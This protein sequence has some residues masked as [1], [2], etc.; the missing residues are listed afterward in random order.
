MQTQF[1]FTTDKAAA[2]AGVAPHVLR[3]HY[4]RHGHY[5]GV[6]PRQ[7]PSRHL[8]W[9]AVG[10]YSAL[11]LLP[12]G[13][14]TPATL[15]RTFVCS[16]TAADPFQAQQVCEHLFSETPK[17]D[18]PAARF[19]YLE[20]RAAHLI[21]HLEAVASVARYT[22]NDEEHLSP[23]GV[24]RLNIL[25]DRISDATAGAV[26]PLRWLTAPPPVSPKPAG[27]FTEGLNRE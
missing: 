8:R 14:P 21:S 23:D 9:P 5:L 3:N 19:E 13:R 6:V 27:M 18:A 4:Y 26:D 22:M 12:A 11:G 25:A 2:V 24:R 15:A 7:L 10:L 16:H 20:A 1:S 17:G